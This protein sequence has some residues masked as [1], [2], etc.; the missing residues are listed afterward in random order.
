MID[1]P[2]LPGSSTPFRY[3]VVVP[4]YNE[5]AVIGEF[6]ELAPSGKLLFSTDGYALPELYLVGAAQFRHSFGRLLAGWVA[7][8]ALPAGDGPRVAALVGAGNARRLYRL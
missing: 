4:V 3:S 7:D 5:A 1:S 8:G 6:C 2:P